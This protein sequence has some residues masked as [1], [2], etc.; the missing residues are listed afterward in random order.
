MLMVSGTD[1]S[2]RDTGIAAGRFDD[3]SA[4]RYQAL[5]FGGRNHRNGNPVFN[6]AKG[7]EKFQ[8]GEDFRF[9]AFGHPVQA[10]QRSGTDG[11]ADV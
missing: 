8:F 7:I 9:Q 1:E 10:H 4:G 11:A 2:Q 3:E 5:P 6:G